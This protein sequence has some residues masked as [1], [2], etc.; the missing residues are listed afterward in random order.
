M[1]NR[2]APLLVLAAV[3]FSHTASANKIKQF[4]IGN[5]QGFDRAPELEV[6]STSGERWTTVDATDTSRVEILLSARCQ[7]EGKGNK[8]Y[9]GNIAVPG[10]ALVG[11]K[12]PAN[13][14]LPHT[15]K[16]SGVF[17][18]DGG[19]GQSF[20][21]VKACNDELDKRVANE[22][23]KTK[24]RFLADGFRVNAPA[25]L[26]VSYTLT[27]QPT[28]AGFTDTDTRSV[29]VNTTVKCG[30]SPLA[31]AMIPS[32]KPKPARAKV[33]PARQPPLLK[34]ATFEAEPEVHTGECPATIRF[35][36]TMTAS[37]AGTVTYQYVRHDGTKSPTFR[38][39]FD[40][41]GT[42]PTRLWQATVAK[43]DAGT[44]LS[45]GSTASG[46]IQGWYRLDVLSPAPTG[47]VVANYRVMCGAGDDEE[48]A[49]ATL[50]AAP[51]ESKP[52]R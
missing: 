48:P 2:L 50:R 40:K 8:A 38:L 1:M 36:G 49:S 5:P 7:W 6:Y 27:C 44:T 46:D 16:A 11:Q 10:F 21:P 17:R 41:A 30:A 23:K 18:W 9:R 47:Q 3:A 33:Q 51:V 12:E 34:A 39:E 31:E 4:S 28:G 20:D 45:A 14:L 32:D 24:Y 37:R 22:P 19:Q 26:R 25:A 13:F 15:D 43:P 52:Q 29:L 35:N 42:K